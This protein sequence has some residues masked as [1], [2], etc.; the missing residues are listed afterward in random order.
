MAFV[1][2]PLNTNLAIG[3]FGGDWARALESQCDGKERTSGPR[4]PSGCDDLSMKIATAALSHMYGDKAVADAIQP[5]LVHLTRWSLDET[6][7]GAYSAPLPGYWDQREILR[8]PVERLFFAGE[9]TARP[10]Y[11]G[12]YPGA[13]ES[14]IDAARAI[15]VAIH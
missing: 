11:N 9:A 10:I 15:H 8:E 14:G 2:K 1:I 12:S 3:F 13:Y 4:S 5:A 7:L 6:S